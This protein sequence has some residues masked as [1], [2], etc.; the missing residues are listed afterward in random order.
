MGKAEVGGMLDEHDVGVQ[1]ADDITIEDGIWND[2]SMNEVV[3]QE[4]E[5][6]WLDAD[7]TVKPNKMEVRPL[8]EYH[9]PAENFLV[10]KGVDI[11]FPAC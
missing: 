2:N 3:V 9:F 6:Q 5:R 10:M 4:A 8:G 7:D 1:K 11:I